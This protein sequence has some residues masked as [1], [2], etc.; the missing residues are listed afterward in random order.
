MQEEIQIRRVESLDSLTD[1]KQRYLDQTTAPL[2][3]MWLCGFVPMATHYGLIQDDEIAGF[4]CCN[5]DNYLLQFFVEQE[6]QQESSRYFKRVLNN[7]EIPKIKGA[8]VSTAE[9]RY[10]SLCLDNLP[11]FEV[12][13]LMYQLE[14]AREA[15]PPADI[16]LRQLESSQLSEAI[17]FAVASIGAPREWLNN[18]YSNLIQRQELYGVWEDQKMIVAGESRGY[19]EFQTEYADVGIVVAPAARG[20]GFG[21][22]VLN[23]LVD[24]NER[25]GLK[26]ICSTE[27]TNIAAQKVIE[28]VGFFPSNRIIQFHTS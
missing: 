6:L 3:G 15:H 13:A 23:Q 17:D 9:P 22:Q 21:T 4:F 11:T 10:L 19:D 27:K 18:Y 1:L 7:A 25:K 26:S 14:G 16:E 20:K 24:I 8:F 2:D 12:N 5:S 28:R